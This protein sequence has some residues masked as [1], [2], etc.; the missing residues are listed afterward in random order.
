MIA[1]AAKGGG[2]KIRLQ[3]A[4]ASLTADLTV[5]KRERRPFSGRLFRV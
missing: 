2:T 5:L 3:L 4:S 1:S